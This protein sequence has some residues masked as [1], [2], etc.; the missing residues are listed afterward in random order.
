MD[1][2]TNPTQYSF[3]LLKNDE[4]IQC[5]GE[6]GIE[7]NINELTEPNKHKDR[8]KS[9]FTS[10]VSL[11]FSSLYFMHFFPSLDSQSID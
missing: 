6:V 5:L 9:T 10:L 3:P 8:V 4:I 7:I 2:T 11:T 1:L